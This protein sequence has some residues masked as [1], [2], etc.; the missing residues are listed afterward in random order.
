MIIIGV[1]EHCAIGEIVT[2]EYAFTD[3]VT[4]VTTFLIVGTATYEEWVAHREEQ[5][6]PLSLVYHNRDAHFYRALTD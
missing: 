3:Q 5:G 6:R 4:V 2:G 1:L